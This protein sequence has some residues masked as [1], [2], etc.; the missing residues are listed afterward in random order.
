MSP[1]P[2][3]RAYCGCLCIYAA[4]YAL[5]TVDG[6]VGAMHCLSNHFHRLSPAFGDGLGKRTRVQ[7]EGQVELENGFSIAGK[8]L[9]SRNAK[10]PSGLPRATLDHYGCD[11]EDP[12]YLSGYLGRFKCRYVYMSW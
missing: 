5:I 7:L 10:M 8:A 6:I 4:V 12:R 1:F 9:C 3:H 2:G 11:S